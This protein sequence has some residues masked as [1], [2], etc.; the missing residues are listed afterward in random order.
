MH[1][2]LLKKRSVARN[3]RVPRHRSIDYWEK[4]PLPN[5]EAPL[6]T[7]HQFQQDP[8]AKAADPVMSITYLGLVLILPTKFHPDLSYSKRFPRFPVPLSTPPPQPHRIWLRF[9]IR[10]LRHE[11]LINK[12]FH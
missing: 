1:S 8:R 9:K 2:L 6:V 3:Q 12:K 5:P 4:H 10:A 11:F 7:P